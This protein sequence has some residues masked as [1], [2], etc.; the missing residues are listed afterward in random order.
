MFDVCYCIMFAV[1]V[2]CSFNPDFFI[3]LCQSEAEPFCS[4]SHI[5]VTLTT[6]FEPIYEHA[7]KHLLVAIKKLFML[8]CT[9]GLFVTLQCF[10]VYIVALY[11]VSVSA[12]RCTHAHAHNQLVILWR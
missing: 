2:L 12:C 4:R 11:L 3:Y 1:Y 5:N 6:V 10:P 9:D 8:L 7:S